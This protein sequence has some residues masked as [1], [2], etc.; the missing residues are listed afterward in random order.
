[1]NYE[2]KIMNYKKS[3][4]CLFSPPSEGS[5]EASPPFF[6]LILRLISRTLPITSQ[7]TCPNV[8]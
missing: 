3:S 8:Y 7:Y 5:G 2:L 1:M 6:Y 4:S